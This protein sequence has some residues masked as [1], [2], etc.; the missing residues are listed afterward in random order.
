MGLFS[1]KKKVVN[2]N[3]KVLET[4]AQLAELL[5]D[6]KE[7]TVAIFKHSTRCGVS[8]MA[9]HR[10]ESEWNFGAEDVDFYY[11]D[12]IQYR[13]ISNRIASDLK[14]THQ[15]PQV[16]VIRNE[17]PVAF[18]SHQAISINW[19]EQSLEKAKSLA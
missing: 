1:T 5:A 7:K 13:S 4:E 16:I 3:W 10:L 9:E 2:T 18:T 6:S 8:S 14:V 15:S 17:K 19:L 11:L 12:L